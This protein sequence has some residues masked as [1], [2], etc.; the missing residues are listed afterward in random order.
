MLGA[1]LS[2]HPAPHFQIIWLCFCVYYQMKRNFIS[3][4]VLPYMG[5]LF[6]KIIL[7][8]NVNSL[9]TTFLLK[10]SCVDTLEVIHKL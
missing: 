1:I 3:I 8:Y 10:L 2:L 7:T 6:R 4:Q 5:I 9:E